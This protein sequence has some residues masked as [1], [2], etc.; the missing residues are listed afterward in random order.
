VRGGDYERWREHLDDRR[1]AVVEEITWDSGLGSVYFHDPAG[2]LLEIAEGDIWPRSAGDT[3]A[4]GQCEGDQAEDKR[5]QRADAC[6][7]AL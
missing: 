4:V 5:K 6:L 3:G 2:N 1:V 7:E